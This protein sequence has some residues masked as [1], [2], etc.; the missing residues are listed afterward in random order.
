MADID[1]E[2]VFNWATGILATAGVLF[3]LF[4]VESGLSPVSV[5][6]LVAAFVLG[7]VALTQRTDDAELRTV[8]YAV[9]VVSGVGL[10]AKFANTFETDAAVT[11]V[12]LLV[13]A[14]ALFG[15]RTRLDDAGGLVDDRRATLLFGAVA[16]LALLVVVG[17]VATGGLGYEL[18]ADDEI[19][20]PDTREEELQVGTLVATNP[21]P[22]PEQVEPPR[23]RACAAGDWSEYRESDEPG[24]PPEE[25]R[26]RLDVERGYDDHVASF[27]ERRYPV[28]LYIGAR[29]VS[30]ERFPVRLVR[31]CP[32]DESGS[33]YVALFPAPDGP[34]A[35]AV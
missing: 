7:V 11:A 24:E 3:F 28:R 25:V 17:D 9:A 10:F 31:T 35:D 4:D 29:N 23:Y 33:A 14:A 27:G 21:T 16:A 2:T 19:R 8:G 1:A 15:L 18:R 32:D 6:L 20:V 26:L 12:G 34:N 22:L 13:L 30:G 5:G